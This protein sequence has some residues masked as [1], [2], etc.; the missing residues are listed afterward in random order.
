MK[1]NGLMEEMMKKE[2]MDG[3]AKMY[4]AT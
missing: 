2:L 1:R 3:E 4:H